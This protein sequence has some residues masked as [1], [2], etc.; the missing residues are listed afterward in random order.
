VPKKSQDEVWT[1]PEPGKASLYVGA[2][3]INVH[4]CGIAQMLFDIRA[5]P[6]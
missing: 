1:L 4:R 5:V 2:K 3:C 6:Q